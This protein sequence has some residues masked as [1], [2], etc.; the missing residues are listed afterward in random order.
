MHTLDIHRKERRK[1]RS[2]QAKAR[3]VGTR[4]P[5]RSRPQV[6]KKTKMGE[7]GAVE[8]HPASIIHVLSYRS[9]CTHPHS[10]T[11]GDGPPASLCIR[12][13]STAGMH[14]DIHTPDPLLSAQRQHLPLFRL[15]VPEDSTCARLGRAGQR[16]IDKRGIR[17][18]IEAKESVR[19]RGRDPKRRRDRGQRLRETPVHVPLPTAPQLP[20]TSRKW[21]GPAS[22]R[23]FLVVL[24]VE[25]PRPRTLSAFLP[26]PQITA[27]VLPSP[28]IS[29]SLLTSSSAASSSPQSR[30]RARLRKIRQCEVKSEV[31]VH[32][33]EKWR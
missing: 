23:V 5:S 19:G 27:P 4:R 3:V 24:A 25:A 8:L 13:A 10:T 22:P 11:S 20:R 28:L 16:R 31:T 29:G 9:G 30:A 12:G 6:T 2:R 18:G 32:I 17:I 1:R 7:E 26:L 14:R 33:K 21:E 15:H